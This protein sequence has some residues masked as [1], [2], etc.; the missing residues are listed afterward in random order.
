MA[1][2]RDTSLALVN[3]AMFLH[4]PQNSELS[5]QVSNHW[6]LKL[7]LFYEVNQLFFIA[8]KRI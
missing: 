8:Y 5:E 3:T 7:T 4:I 6:V 2:D 1:Q